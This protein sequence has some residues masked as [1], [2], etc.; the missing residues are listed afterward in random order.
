MA[1]KKER[2]R[3]R[4]REGGTETETDREWNGGEDGNREEYR[5]PKKHLT[6]ES[7]KD[8]LSND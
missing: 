2:E 1:T 4:E 3:E 5:K 7:E 6:T 8:T